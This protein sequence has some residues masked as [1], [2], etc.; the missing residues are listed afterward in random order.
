MLAADT[1]RVSLG[2]IERDLP[3]LDVALVA[4][5]DDR[6]LCGEVPLQLLDPHAHLVP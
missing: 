6:R 2:L 4:G 1:H 5:D 3:I